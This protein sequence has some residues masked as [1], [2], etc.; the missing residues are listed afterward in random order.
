MPMNWE[1]EENIR[2]TTPRLVLRPLTVGDDDAMYAL[3]AHDRDVLRYFIMPYAEERS[4]F[5]MERSI[6]ACRAGKKHILALVEKETDEVC[7]MMLM[8]S[9]PNPVFN[10][11]EVG[12]ALGRKFQRRGLCA[13][14]LK[15][16]TE[17]LFSKGV[18]KVFCACIAENTASRRVMEKCGMT[19]EGSRKD[20]IFYRGRY[21][22][23]DVFYRLAP[24]HGKPSSV[25]P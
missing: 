16:F 4:G 21:W 8:C 7:G 3:I 2:L 9:A 25:Q 14:A 1:L 22:D 18:H 23:T 20:E 17:Y 5:T 19:Y 13:E 11:C 6:E 12:Y 10:A 24:E 15:A